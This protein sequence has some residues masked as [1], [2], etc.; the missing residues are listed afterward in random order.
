MF[1]G[2]WMI[3]LILMH[4]SDLEENENGLTSGN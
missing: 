2:G 3:F 1:D 4:F